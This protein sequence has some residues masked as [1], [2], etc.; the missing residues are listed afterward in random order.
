MISMLVVAAF[1][2]QQSATPTV[3]QARVEGTVLN[4]LNGQ[5]VRKVT[6][7][8]RAHDTDEALSYADETDANGHFSIADVSPGDYALAAER[9]GFR[10]QS[11]GAIGAPPPN[12][13]LE[14][15][16]QITG[17]TIRL[18]P[19][20]V[21]A[22]RVLDADGDPVRGANVTAF[23]YV[24][25]SG[26]KELRSVAQ[27]QSGDNGDFRLFGLVE[28][29]F[30]LKSSATRRLGLAGSVPSFY[31][32]TVDETH[33]EPVVVHPGAQLEGFDI[34]LQSTGVYGVRFKLP[35]SDS[36]EARTSITAFLGNGQPPEF[37]NVATWSPAGLAFNDVPPGSYELMV[38]R[39]DAGKQS[40]AFR[41]VEVANADVDG[42][43]LTFLPAVDVAGSVRIEGGAFTSG[44]DKL[45]LTLQSPPPSPGTG[46]LG[47]QVKPDGTFLLKNAAPAVYE[48]AING[49]RGLYLKSVRIRDK[50]LPDRRID[51]TAPPEA[52]TVVL[53]N[54]V[55]E[56]EGSVENA[57]GQP[58][59]RARVT[60]IAYG[61][62]SGRI[63]LSRFA[64]TDDK[65]EFTVKDVA[66]GDYKVF[67][68]E[69]VP[70]GAPQDP[71]FRKPFEK[72]AAALQMPPNGHQKIQLT[73]IP[74]QDNSPQ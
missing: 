47:A 16:Q 57:K 17:L 60:V 52:L 45:R 48:V 23:R 74:A 69:N 31:P 19:L 6:V 28:G 49:V 32:G 11:T 65:G 55:G 34:R 70:V 30:Y 63:D 54:D 50:T 42:G 22:G 67:A 5:P 1:L 13:K 43:M 7:I 10:Q 9:P 12:L 4:S 33:A 26:K 36:A 20:G 15:G 8:L 14:S 2:A 66:P 41:H 25:S 73:A 68:W 59:A 72:Q 46:N 38:I 62:H 35:A 27:A 53:G 61:D 18:T 3:V 51:L 29:T 39:R 21:I 37:N 24:Y 44:Y 58:V 71:E 40:Y 56:V 64:F